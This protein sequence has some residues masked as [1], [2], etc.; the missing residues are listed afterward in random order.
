MDDWVVA[1]AA[2]IDRH[3]GP[4]GLVGH[5][6]GGNV[7]WGAAAAR[8][9]RVARVVFVDTVPLTRS[10]PAQAPTSPVTLDDDRRF[11]VPVTLLMGSLDEAAL[12]AE[13]AR[14]GPYAEEFAAIDDATVVR[15]GTGHWPQFSAPAALARALVEAFAEDAPWEDAPA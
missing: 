9:D 5:S 2:E 3:E 11:G 13:L 6:G 8:P 15:L 4:V 7:V 10:I 1:V 12:R 14:W